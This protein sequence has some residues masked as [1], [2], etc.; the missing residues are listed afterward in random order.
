M[1]RRDAGALFFI[2]AGRSLERGVSLVGPLGLR[3]V[4]IA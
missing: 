4:L 3:D 2:F 1:R